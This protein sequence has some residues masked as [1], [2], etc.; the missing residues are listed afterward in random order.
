MQLIVQI[1]ELAC[2]VIG[3]GDIPV[4]VVLIEHFHHVVKLYESYFLLIEGTQKARWQVF[5]VCACLTNGYD[6]LYERSEDVFFGSCLGL[7][8]KEIF[9]VEEFRAIF[10]LAE[11]HGKVDVAKY[12]SGIVFLKELVGSS[13]PLLLSCCCLPYLFERCFLLMN[14]IFFSQILRV[15]G[16]WNALN[17]R[18]VAAF[19][20][21]DIRFYSIN[22]PRSMGHCVTDS[23]FCIRLA[24]IVSF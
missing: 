10:M 8:P 19:M 4:K 17:V 24:V 23:A 9:A 6:E 15:T 13:L 11:C 20:S 3:W 2:F 21:D 1:L 14:S 7:C 22:Q 12:G 18:F 16:F 5:F